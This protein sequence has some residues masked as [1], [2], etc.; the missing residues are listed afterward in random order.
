LRL[1]LFFDRPAISAFELDGTSFAA[2]EFALLGD[3]D[4]HLLI[5][6]VGH[7]E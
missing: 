6:L 7:F 4:V 3:L 5:A 1:L 2:T